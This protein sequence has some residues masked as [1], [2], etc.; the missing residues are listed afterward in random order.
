MAA[1]CGARSTVTVTLVPHAC[2]AARLAARRLF[3]TSRALLGTGR[4]SYRGRHIVHGRR[5]RDTARAHTRIGSL[6]KFSCCPS[7][8]MP[9]CSWWRAA[10]LVA[11]FAAVCPVLLVGYLDAHP[12]SGIW[13][14]LAANRVYSKEYMLRTVKEN[15]KQ[16]LLI[17]LG[18]VY[19]VSAG[20]GFYSPGAEYHGYCLGRDHTLA[21]LTAD[22]EKDSTDDLSELMPAQCLGIEHW[23]EFYAVEKNDTYQCALRRSFI[24]QPGCPRFPP[25]APRE[26]PRQ[27]RSAAAAAQLHGPARGALL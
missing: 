15:K 13:A 27:L 8:T 24:T 18:R 1:A 5:E 17:I 23:S 19:D 12:H 7:S 3:P 14:W 22:F 21:F 4:A 16:L 9:A 11:I 6:G 20:K 25:H 10:A 2:A 26:N